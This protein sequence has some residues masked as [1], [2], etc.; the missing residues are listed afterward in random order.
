MRFA[1]LFLALSVLLV[2]A[3]PT[4]ANAQDGSAVVAKDAAAAEPAAAPA[5]KKLADAD[6][7]APLPK[8]D[9]DN[10]SQIFGYIIE[11]FKT[12]KYAWGFGLIFMLLTW[13]LSR[14]VLKDR[15]PKRVLPW[16]AV[17]L[18]T[19]TAIAVSFAS[20]VVWYTALSNGFTVGLAAIGGW[21]ALTKMFKKDPPASVTPAPAASEAGS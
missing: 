3:I 4:D 17:G 8:V 11:A 12:G 20:G 21:E 2:A 1:S 7:A 19:G 5:T 18:S 9:P 6:K 10:P 15:V 13:F 14:K 16:V